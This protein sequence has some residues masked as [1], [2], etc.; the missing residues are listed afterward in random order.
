VVLRLGWGQAALSSILVPRQMSLTQ[1][2][3]D[4]R[5]WINLASLP[6]F[7][8]LAAW[9]GRRWPTSDTLPFWVV[10]VAILE[11]VLFAPGV[12]VNS[13]VAYDLIFALSWAVGRICARADDP[14]G[15]MVVAAGMVFHLA[16]TMP[17]QPARVM[18]GAAP[19]KAVEEQSILKDVAWLRAH[20]GRAICFDLALCYYA[21]DDFEYDR[22]NMGQQF[23]HKRRDRKELFDP[24]EAHVFAVIELERGD[25]DN[26]QSEFQAELNRI[27]L[28]N[29][30]IVRENDDRVFL[31]PL[32]N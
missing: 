29:Y 5:N 16:L 8:V 22:F 25:I 20:P 27:I 11:I 14:R 24:I 17:M 28:A 4:T 30:R 21:G 6:L 31:V 13:N 19:G 1:G 7:V 3:A 9:I 18:F 26:T 23:I 10:L 12:G 2:F 32:A 15:G